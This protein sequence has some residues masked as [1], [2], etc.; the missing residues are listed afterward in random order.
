MKKTPSRRDRCFA[1]QDRS[2]DDGHPRF[3]YSG[4]TSAVGS[5]RRVHKTLATSSEGQTEA[6]PPL[7][8]AKVCPR[9][10]KDI[11]VVGV[12]RARKGVLL[13]T[14]GVATF[15]TM[16]AQDEGEAHGPCV[17][18]K[19]W[20]DLGIVDAASFRTLVGIS[21]MDI[22]VPM[23][24]NGAGYVV[25]FATCGLSGSTQ[26]SHLILWSSFGVLEA[27]IHVKSETSYF[28]HKHIWSS[29][30]TIAIRTSCAGRDGS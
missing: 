23:S 28:T 1:Y 12:K 18:A 14:S 24:R 7:R 6:R 30:A 20:T 22:K 11:E 8:A 10:D 21:G 4:G 26:T 15:M 2:E 3:D 29:V 5:R 19:T 13:A 17:C 16:C 27:E 25:W 9:R